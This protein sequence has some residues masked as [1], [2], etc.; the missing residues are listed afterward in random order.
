MSRLQ[1]RAHTRAHGHSVA[2]HAPAWATV[3]VAL[4]A[5]A[6]LALVVVGCSAKPGPTQEFTV[7]EPLGSAAITDVQLKMGAGKLTLQPGA[8]GLISGVIRYNILSWKPSVKRTDSQLI[9]DQGNPS[10]GG[11]L[12]S[13]VNDWTLQL[14]KAPMTLRIDAGAYEGDLDLSGLTLR[15][16]AIRDGA[17]KVQVKFTAPNPGQ[18]DSFT[19]NTGAST[20]VL[21]G[22]A[23]ANFQQM[24][25]QGGAGAY[26]LDFSGDL[27]TDATVS[28]K[29]GVGSV[30]ISVPPG[31]SSQVNV[32]GALTKVSAQG[33]WTTVGKTYSTAGSG[34]SLTINVE[35]SVGTL[36]L[37]SQ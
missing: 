36:K 10:A 4:V 16:L 26:A 5:T 2:R 21:A 17:S 7:N 6:V 19:Y 28:I 14:G 9:I 32:S 29:A 13:I 1:A 33:S 15:S 35:M 23:N 34:K 31:T 22:L 37:I 3:M 25:F 12:G 20:V 27:R 24:K 18:M 8:S 11:L 30:Q